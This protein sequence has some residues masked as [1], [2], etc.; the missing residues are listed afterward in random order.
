MKRLSKSYLILFLVLSIIFSVCSTQKVVETKIEKKETKIGV[1]EKQEKEKPRRIFLD[2]IGDTQALQLYADGFE[3]LSLKNKMLAYYLYKAG[4]AGRDIFWDQCNKYSLEIRDICEE[5]YKHPEGIDPDVYNDIKVYT[6]RMWLESGRYRQGNKM[7]FTPDCTFEEFSEAARIAAKRGAKFNLKKGESIESRL[8]FLK[9]FM[10]DPDFQ[11]MACAKTPPEGEDIL[12]A[13]HNNFYENVTLA[14][15]KE[16]SK[17]G[18]EKNPLNSKVTKRHGKIIERVWRAGSPKIDVAPGMYAEQIRE[19]IFWLEKAIPYAEPEQ[20]EVIKAL[21]KYYKT[22]DLEDFDDFNI[23]WVKTNPMV[24]F[25]NGFVEV[26]FDAR[27]QKGSYQ[28]V[29]YFVDM[30]AKEF[31]NKFAEMA[32]YFEQKAPWVDKYKKKEFNIVPVS[33][34]M[35]VLHAT[36]DM[37]PQCPGGVNLPNAQW[38][39]EQYGSK[40]VMLGNIMGGSVKATKIPPFKPNE[41]QKE[42]YHPD[43]L[44][45]RKTVDGNTGYTLVTLHEIV[46]HGSGKVPDLEGDPSEYIQEYYNTLEESRADL[47]AYWNVHD[48]KLR[49]IGA[50][51]SE[52]AADAVFWSIARRIIEYP[53]RYAGYDRI[54]QDHARGRYMVANYLYK[55]CNAIQ[56]DEIDGKLYAKPVS[57]EKMRE[58]VG[59]LL[60]EIMRIKAEGDY[61]AAKNLIDTYGTYI[62]KEIQA[63]MIER[64]KNF[65]K[66]MSKGEEQTEPAIRF[67]G[68]SMP[69]LKAVK[70][71][72]GEIIDIKVEYWQ[73]F[74]KEMLYYSSGEWR[75]H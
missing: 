68:W 71:G 12:T 45:F 36:G 20:Q 61:E 40:N 13:S 58:G 29:V 55:K 41:Y 52:K 53:M 5:I 21:I 74:A 28:N 6:H 9:P 4:L 32:S 16:W 73:D 11:P 14:E 59:E 63:K 49:E 18:N 26:Y 69:I 24:D 15:V 50:V 3:N 31:I 67:R 62:D 70:D 33:N 2:R 75:Y 22:G 54:E 72:N 65:R 64:M 25:M 1:V 60:A 48:P 37:A 66:Q 39:R 34:N 51:Y 35:I 56:L 38:I 42:F 46:G 57:V 43:E 17:A 8:I 23:K 27:G 47:M 30:K 44:E 7:K 19:I 10:F